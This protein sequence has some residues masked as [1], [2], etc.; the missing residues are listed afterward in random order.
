MEGDSPYLTRLSDTWREH[1]LAAVDQLP[2]L[3]EGDVTEFLP[4]R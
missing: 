2:D 4:D 3:E 1:L